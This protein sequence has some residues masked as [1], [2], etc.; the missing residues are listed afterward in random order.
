M[1]ELNRTVR[2][3]FLSQTKA[4]GMILVEEPTWNNLVEKQ[5][6]VEALRKKK[7]KE[8]KSLDDFIE[9]FETFKKTGK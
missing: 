9:G 4:K 2:A 8:S 3:E 6:V 7:T 1:S 5:R